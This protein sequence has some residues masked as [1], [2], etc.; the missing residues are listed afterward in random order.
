MIKFSII[1]PTFNSAVHIHDC[2]LSVLEQS[3]DDFE[4]IIIDNLSTDTT[5]QI[6]TEMYGRAGKSGKLKIISEADTGIAD[7][8]NKGVMNASGQ[9]ILIL[10]SDDRLY[11][12]SVLQQINQFSATGDYLIIHSDMFFEDNTFGSNRRAPL[13][14]AVEAAMPYNHPGMFIHR[15]V[16]RDYGLYNTG[17]RVAMDYEMIVRLEVLTPDIKTRTGY[18]NNIPVTISKAGGISWTSEQKGI[19][20]VKKALKEHGRYNIAAKYYYWVRTFRTK[21]KNVLLRLNLQVIVKLWRKNK[22]GN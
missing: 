3:F 7:A 5:L 16:Y 14:C 8:F 21:V 15:D 10:N 4:H 6:I 13:L 11:D 17:Y 22:W 2:I 1:T 18:F 19:D 20:E 12:A 9:F